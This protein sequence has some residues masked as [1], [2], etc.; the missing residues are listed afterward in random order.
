[1]LAITS[2]SWRGRLGLSLYSCCDVKVEIVALLGYWEIPLELGVEPESS[3]LDD[4]ADTDAALR[5]V[6]VRLVLS[7]I[8]I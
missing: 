5:L 6:S 1:M 3:E 7:C 4:K 8:I 2:G